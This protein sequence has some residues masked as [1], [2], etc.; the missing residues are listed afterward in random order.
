MNIK[1][2]DRIGKYLQLD[3]YY[4]IKNA[5]YLI[6]SQLGTDLARFALSIA[7]AWLVT[8]EVYGQWNFILSVVGICI[9]LTLP[10]MGTAITQSVSTGHDRVLVRGT[11][12]RFKWGIWGTIAVLGVGIYYFL[13]GDATIGKS[14]MIASLLFPFYHCFHTFAA[15]FSG[16]KQFNKVAKYQLITQVVSVLVTIAVIYFSRSLILIVTIYLFSFSVLRGYF[17]RSAYQNMEN[18]SDDP[19]AV[20]FGGHLTVSIIPTEIRQHYDRII[21]ALFLSFP[22][23]AIYAIALGFADIVFS[24]SSIIATLILPK[25][26]QMDEATAYREVKKKWPLL[27][28]GFGIICGILI[29]L[30]PYI[31]PFFYSSKYLDSVFYAQILLISVII[32]APVPIINKALLPSQK[33]IKDLY[34]LRIYSAL[35]EI[36]LLTVLTLKFGLIGVVIAILLGRTF[37][38]AYS[39]ILARFIPFRSLKRT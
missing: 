30:C 2:L 38:T 5:I 31:I 23:L 29:A 27:V 13:S 3:L 8:Q 11:K 4:Y 17:F 32:A 1:L 6:S 7:F 28:L 19:Q 12:Q 37:T 21:I 15:F 20:T 16:K 9:I 35:I 34:K 18:Q 33:K 14:L 10:G 25:L 39:L 24:F 22:E 26:S 36:I